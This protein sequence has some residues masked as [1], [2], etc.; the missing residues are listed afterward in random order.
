MCTFCLPYTHT[1]DENLHKHR[2][3][4]SS[5]I[6]Q[7]DTEFFFANVTQEEIMHLFTFDHSQLF[8]NNIW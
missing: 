3:S 7:F 2:I 6:A 5:F 8:I 1:K 4:L